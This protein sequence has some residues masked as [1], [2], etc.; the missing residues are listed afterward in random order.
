[1]TLWLHGWRE[2]LIHLNLFLD[3][4]LQVLCPPDLFYIKL[5]SQFD[6]WI[7]GHWNILFIYQFSIFI[8]IFFIS[9]WR[10][11][12]SVEY[13]LLFSLFRDQTTHFLYVSP[14]PSSASGP[15]KQLHAAC[16][17]FHGKPIKL[18]DRLDV[19]LFFELGNL[20]DNFAISC[21][22]VTIS[23]T[24]LFMKMCSDL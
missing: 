6:P 9:A 14:I 21:L 3:F 8:L 7:L 22:A 12:R 15:E 16:Q 5:K 19:Q 10:Y 18:N 23:W 4:C 13:E 24:E 17:N 2:K 20:R 1:M 11:L